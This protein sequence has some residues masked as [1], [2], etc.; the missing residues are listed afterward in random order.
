MQ[1]LEKKFEEISEICYKNWN[2]N[3]TLIKAQF[4]CREPVRYEPIRFS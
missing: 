4:P 1:Q 2:D 3:Q